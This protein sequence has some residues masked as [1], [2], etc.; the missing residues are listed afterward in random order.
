VH[1]ACDG[2]HPPH[3]RRAGGAAEVRLGTIAIRR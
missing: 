3:A 1:F 2:G